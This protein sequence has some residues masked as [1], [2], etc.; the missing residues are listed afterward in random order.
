[1]LL[2]DVAPARAGRQ[3]YDVHGYLDGRAGT[4]LRST[5]ARINALEIAPIVVRSR[6]SKGFPAGV[7]Y[8]SLYDTTVFVDESIHEVFK[9]LVEA[10]MLVFLVVLVFLQDWRAT[11]IP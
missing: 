3:N 2:C 4:V 6:T 11:M 1:M 5:R 8:G 10:F 9:T 7:E